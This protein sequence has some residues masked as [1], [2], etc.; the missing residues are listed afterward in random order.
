[1]R[2]GRRH[3]AGSV[4]SRYCGFGSALHP[5]SFAQ[6]S[7]VDTASPAETSR[8]PR[9]SPAS[10]SKSPKVS[11]GTNRYD[12]AISTIILISVCSETCI[13]FRE[14]RPSSGHGQGAAAG[15]LARLARTLPGL[16][17]RAGRVVPAHCAWPGSAVLLGRLWIC[18]GGHARQGRQG[19]RQGG[20]RRALRAQEDCSGCR[21]HVR[22]VGMADNGQRRDPG[23]H[24]QPS[25]A[26]RK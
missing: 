17:E 16:C 7:P 24:H 5:R 23:L 20:G 4:H 22:H 26:F 12:V 15:P 1:V 9:S 11:E 8:A 6:V 25:G 18:A 19:A 10:F 3:D 2:P 14:R 21:R 13:L